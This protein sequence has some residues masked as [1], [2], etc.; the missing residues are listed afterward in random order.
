MSSS[1]SG[2][3]IPSPSPMRRHCARSAW[4]PWDR[5]GYHASG[6]LTVRPSI[7]STTSAS[8][9]RAT[10]SARASRISFAADEVL[11]PGSQKLLL[12]CYHQ[13][14][15][16]PEF[17]RSEP[18]AARKPHRIEPEFRTVRLPLH[19]NMRRLR[20]VGRVEEEPVRTLTMNGRHDSSVTSTCASFWAAQ[21]RY[22]NRGDFVLCLA[23]VSAHQ[24]REGRASGPTRRLVQRVL[25]G[26]LNDAASPAPTRE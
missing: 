22:P 14:F 25:D 26:P 10:R 19:V 20:A 8:S 5:R 2:Q 21:L 4:V 12:P 15:D 24:R 9:V 18:A 7:N 3:W 17:G 6:T 13:P 16:L 23:N 11:I 1:R